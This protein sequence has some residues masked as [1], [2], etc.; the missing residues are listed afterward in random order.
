MSPD[1]P[2]PAPHVDDS[3]VPLPTSDADMDVAAA[4]LAKFPEGYAT[5]CDH[6]REMARRFAESRDALKHECR[7]LKNQLTAAEATRHQV[8]QRVVDYN[9]EYLK[10]TATLTAQLA[11]AE[12]SRDALIA[13]L[14]TLRDDLKFVR[15]ALYED[16]AGAPVWDLL[17]AVG[18]SLER[19]GGG[20]LADRCHIM[21]NVLE[22]LAPK[23][24][25]GLAAARAVVP[26]DKE[27]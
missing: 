18:D 22:L 15:A 24:T 19:S 23:L 12:A 21:A 10:G 7:D 6:Y 2:P 20:P 25:A 14:A 11:A 26:A 4:E 8:E 3:L 5:I 16:A 9:A 17:R 13:Q 1:G 27:V